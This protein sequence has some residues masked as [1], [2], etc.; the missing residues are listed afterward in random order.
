MDN[1]PSRDPAVSATTI[2]DDGIDICFINK[3]GWVS[4]GNSRDYGSQVPAPST[5]PALPSRSPTDAATGVGENS[6]STSVAGQ[7]HGTST[8]ENQDQTSVTPTANNSIQSRAS[9]KSFQ[10]SV[11]VS[12]TSIIPEKILLLEELKC[13]LAQKPAPK[14]NDSYFTLM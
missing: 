11:G 9:E 8:H 6:A 3:A 7:S 2:R 13:H 4:L 10:R 5:G 12:E 14:P 1:P